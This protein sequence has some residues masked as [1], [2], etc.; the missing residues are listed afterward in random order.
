MS[1]LRDR[2]FLR[3]LIVFTAVFAFC[4][5]GSLA[6]IGLSAPGGQ[7]SP[8]VARYLDFISWIRW[9]LLAGSKGFLSIVGIDTYIT[10]Q[11]HI[12]YVNGK[13]V[14][15]AYDC[16]GYGV[17]SFWIA[18]VTALPGTFK[19]KLSWILKGIF[20]L[21]LINVA[22]ISLFLVVTNRN[23]EMPLGL[24]HHTWFNIFA[25]LAIFIL[26]YFLNRSTGMRLKQGKENSK[27]SNTTS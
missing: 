16:I 1:I 7:Y 11:Y 4:Y 9:A 12:R 8:F 2:F 22:R 21:Y 14:F 3:F 17:M 19:N 23:T 18:L 15:L 27:N 20:I 25:Y 6:V 24:D 13:G 5:F 10:P 26:L